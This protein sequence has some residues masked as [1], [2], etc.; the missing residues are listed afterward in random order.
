V[1]YQPGQSGNPSGRPR[2]VGKQARYR[3]LLESHA[4]K[5]IQKAV[6]MALEGDTTA[7]KLCIERLLPPTR[8]EAVKLPLNGT[9]SQQGQQILH[10]LGTGSLRSCK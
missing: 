1:K 8:E 10:T 3:K 4:D 2:G 7:L 6:D 9:L 5:L